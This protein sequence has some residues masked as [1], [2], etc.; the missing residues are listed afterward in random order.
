MENINPFLV[1]AIVFGSGVL[2]TVGFL[3]FWKV[4]IWFFEDFMDF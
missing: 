3:V 2:I 1:V 4:A